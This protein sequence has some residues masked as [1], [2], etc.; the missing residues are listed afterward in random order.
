MTENR[1]TR[2][3]WF[4]FS[5]RTFLIVITLVGFGGAWLGMQ[6]QQKRRH[7]AVVKE[8]V[9]SGGRVYFLHA[10]EVPAWKEWLFGS[11]AVKTFDLVL[12]NT[13]DPDSLLSQMQGMNLFSLKL[14]STE[15]TD[16][17]LTHLIRLTSLKCLYLSN[18][19][20]TDA[21]LTHLEKMTGLEALGLANT[22]ISDAGL[23]HLK[24]L[25]GLDTLD[26]SN[27]Q[28]TDAGLTQL[29]GLIRLEYLDLDN[30]NVTDTGLIH[31]EGLTNLASLDLIH[32]QVTQAGVD[33][34]Y[35][36]IPS[37]GVSFR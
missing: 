4:Q 23:T 15:V 22:Q 13:D 27:T 33:R 31:L 20:I 11:Y 7:E 26:L 19:Q 2:R 34:I 8:I 9:R 14:S 24:E 3:R 37:C 28:I 1:P 17:G 12:H 10:E 6:L 21:G 18:T 25:T 32:T 36:A 30:T 35:E 29:K 5:L 16:D